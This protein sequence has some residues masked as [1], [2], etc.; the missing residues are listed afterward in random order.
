MRRT[1]PVSIADLY[2]F[3]IPI[4]PSVSPD[5]KRVV[6]TLERMHKQDKTYY[7]SL[8]MTGTN[9]RGLKQLTFGKRNDRS[10]IWSPNGEQIAFI[11][12]R[13]TASQILDTFHEGW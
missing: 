6:F 8:H 4:E 2:R 13:E 12:K 3:K 9:G 10:P 7:T 5:G 1:Q 11:S